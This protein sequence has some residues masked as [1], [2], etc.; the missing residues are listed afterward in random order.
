M[1]TFTTTF[2]VSDQKVAELINAVC[3]FTGYQENIKNP[4]YD[5]NEWLD[6]PTN[7]VPNPDYDPNPT[8]PN[9]VTKAQH[10][11]QAANAVM[12]RWLR[13]HYTKW[14][15]ATDSSVQL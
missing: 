6:K 7:S 5:S 8:I 11:Q 15:L 2:T 12:E 9:P 3:Y 10:A 14:K 13:E 4:N 1:A